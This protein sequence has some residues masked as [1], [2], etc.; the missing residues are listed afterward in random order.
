MLPRFFPAALMASLCG[1]NLWAEVRQ[2]DISRFDHVRFLGEGDITIVQGDVEYL[3]G[4]GNT[5]TLDRVEVAMDDSTLVIKTRR[6]HGDLRFEIGVKELSGLLVA[7]NAEVEIG[8]LKTRALDLAG[9]G[10]TSI[11]IEALDVD[12]LTVSNSGDSNVHIAGRARHQDVRVTGDG[13]YSALDLETEDSD[14]RVSGD[15]W[16]QVNASDTL[17]VSVFGDGRISYRG[18]PRVSQRVMGHGSIRPLGPH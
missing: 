9:S 7:G 8:R 2:F 18:S 6:R 11:D 12:E 1:V 4:H 14:I 16:V 15:G 17:D 5:R 13:E 10:D 3:R